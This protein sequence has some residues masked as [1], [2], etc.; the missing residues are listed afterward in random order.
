MKFLIDNALSPRVAALLAAAGH[1][2]VHVR[3]VG[4][5]RA[6]DAEVFDHAV[7]EQRVLISTDTDFA[8]L[9]A[10][11]AGSTPS[12]VL[13][14]GGF[15]RKP[16]GPARTLLA[17][18]PILESELERGAI[19]VISDRLRIRPLPLRGRNE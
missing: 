15:D 9:I 18:L 10:H 6:S 1:D 5:S 17:M 4:L 2:A 19:A 3:A 16:E 11:R 13:F 12:L 7:R 14:R 8:A